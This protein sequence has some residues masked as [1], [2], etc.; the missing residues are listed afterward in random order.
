MLC[1]STGTHVHT[2]HEGSAV[3]RRCW[4]FEECKSRLGW[5]HIRSANMGGHLT[6]GIMGRVKGIVTYSLS[7]FE[8][9]A[10]AGLISN[11]CGRV[12]SVCS[13]S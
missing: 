2:T 3:L 11:V 1:V 12:L 6:W 13:Q 7:P 5:V 9:R 8:Q 10:F 4:F